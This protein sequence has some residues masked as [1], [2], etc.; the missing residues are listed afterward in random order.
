MDIDLVILVLLV[1][2]VWF[3]YNEKMTSPPIPGIG[4]N[5]GNALIGLPA[6]VNKEAMSTNSYFKDKKIN[7]IGAPDLSKLPLADP[8]LPNYLSKTNPP[9]IFPYSRTKRNF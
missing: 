4:N 2:G 8:V 9:P 6:Q 7:N 1:G 5:S 3:F